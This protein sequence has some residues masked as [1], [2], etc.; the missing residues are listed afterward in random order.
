MVVMGTVPPCLTTGE[1][2]K[3]TL[4][5]AC[6]PAL[7]VVRDV[8]VSAHS[9]ALGVRAHTLCVWF[10]KSFINVTR[11]PFQTSVTAWLDFLISF[12]GFWQ[13]LLTF[14][15]PLFILIRSSCGYWES[16]K[17]TPTFV[18][19]RRD[20]LNNSKTNLYRSIIWRAK[21]VLFTEG[22]HESGHYCR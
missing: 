21:L 17:I 22:I 1:D 16:R 2:K 19:T 7:A 3:C 14:N 11:F 10:T 15:T 20:I 5:T 9:F 18:N 6:A 13:I 4:I 8:H 12:W